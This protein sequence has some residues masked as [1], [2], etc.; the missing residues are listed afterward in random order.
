MILPAGLIWDGD[1][2][3]RSKQLSNTVFFAVETL[4]TLLHPKEDSALKLP[5][6]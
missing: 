6:I 2:H 3:E 5:A 4:H 1:V